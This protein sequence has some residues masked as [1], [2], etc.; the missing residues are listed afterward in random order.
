MR[1]I[2]SRKGFDAQYGGGPSP[3]LPNGKMF[4]LPIPHPM[5]P[6]T[7]Q[8]IASPIGH[9]G[10]IIDQLKHK[11]ISPNDSTHL[12]PDIYPDSLPRHP[13]WNCCFGQYGAAQQHLSNQG[14]TVGD[15][16]LFFGW[17]RRVDEKLHPLPKEPD[18]HVIYG[19][20][21]IQ[22][23]INI[24]TDIHTAAKHYPAYADHPHLTHSFGVNNTLY[25]AR[26]NLKIGTQELNIPGGGIFSQINDD[27]ILTA[28]CSTR[29]IWHL[30]KWFADPTPAL[31]YHLKTD[32]WAA[33]P[34]GWKVKSAPKGQEFVINTQGRNQS[35]N[36]WLKKLFCDQISE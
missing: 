12:D 7:Y 14:V 29:S 33:T 3:I 32:K 31:S 26:D 2:L 36:R 5:G 35:A 1:I 9:L 27:R 17:F 19:W 4:S 13:D 10:A 21:Q 23:V 16:F 34:K 28:A 6:K 24:G 8:D 18:L 11:K 22:E 30:P 15:L 20:L 25:I